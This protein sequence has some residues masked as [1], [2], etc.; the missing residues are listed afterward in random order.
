MST[1]L[2]V[3]IN[4]W[5]HSES[6]VNEIGWLDIEDRATAL[7]G[8]VTSLKASPHSCASHVLGFFEGSR[9]PAFHSN[10]TKSSIS[11]IG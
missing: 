10:V 5:I 6:S 2:C 1:S 8:T 4:D 7:V 3:I 9:T 11:E